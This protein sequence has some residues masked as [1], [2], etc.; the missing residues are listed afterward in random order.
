MSLSVRLLLSHVCSVAEGEKKK[1]KQEEEGI[2]NDALNKQLVHHLFLKKK[3]ASLM[4]FIV[5][6]VSVYMVA[7]FELQWK[8][9]SVHLH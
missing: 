7:W 3:T 9:L 6:S 8:V 4:C 2:R 1:K 5:T